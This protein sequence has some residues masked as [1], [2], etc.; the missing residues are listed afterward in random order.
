[1]AL[2]VYTAS[3]SEGQEDADHFEA[4]T[5][6]RYTFHRP[7]HRSA[8]HRRR[9]VVGER[10]VG[11]E[12]PTTASPR[13]LPLSLPLAIAVLVAVLAANLVLTVLIATGLH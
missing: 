2:R 7:L 9:V 1:M 13:I 11:P 4:I 12:S 3:R 5:V 10:P 8:R 6:S